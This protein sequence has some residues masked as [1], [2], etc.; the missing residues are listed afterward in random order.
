MMLDNVYT[1]I[2]GP[3]SPPVPQSLLIPLGKYHPANYKSPVSDSISAPTSAPR[4]ASLPTTSLVIPPSS[5]KR[6]SRER[7]GHERKSSDVKRK[8]QQYQRD[9]IVQAQLAATASTGHRIERATPT[10]PRLIPAGSPGPIT[11]FELEG[12]SDGYIIAGNKAK[13]GFLVG[14]GIE[15]E[16][17]ARRPQ[18]TVTKELERGSGARV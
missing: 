11:P 2:P 9:M 17:E 6:G 3:I 12:E 8:L 13:T 1:P 18:A 10:N 4:K 7:P 14:N 5:T 15:K 16:Q